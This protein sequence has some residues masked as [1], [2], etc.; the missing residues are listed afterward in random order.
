[1]LIVYAFI[2]FF[3]HSNRNRR[4]GGD[5]HS[6]PS[7]RRAKHI[8]MEC[9]AMVGQGNCGFYLDLIYSFPD[10]TVLKRAPCQYALKSCTNEQVEEKCRLCY[11]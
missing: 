7:K 2:T 3:H 1:M 6:C 11:W 8:S 10:L 9:D 5:E 4:T